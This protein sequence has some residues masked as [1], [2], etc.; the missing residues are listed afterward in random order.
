MNFSKCICKL[1]LCKCHHSQDI[2]HFHHPLKYNFCPFAVNL[3]PPTPAP[4]I[5]FLVSQYVFFFPECHRNEIKQHVSFEAWLMSLRLMLLRFI[6]ALAG[7]SGVFYCWIL[8]ITICWSINKLRGIWVLCSLFLRIKWLC[9][10]S[11][12]VWPTLC[13]P[14]DRSPPGFSVD[15]ILQARILEWV[16]MPSS[17]GIFLTQ[18]SNLILLC[19]LHWQASS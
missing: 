18:A 11:L 17:R 4:V 5:C 15:G 1:Q 7:F 19:L 9:T 16:A 12:Q 10:K 13:S 8:Q 6:H 2:E 14:I 3:Q